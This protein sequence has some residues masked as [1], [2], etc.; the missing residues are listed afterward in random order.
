MS[1]HPS[2]SED[3]YD[4]SGFPAPPDWV[5]V[6]EVL[7]RAREA[8][9]ARLQEA[10]ELVEAQLEQREETYRETASELSTRIERYEDELEHM[11][12]LFRGSKE[13]RRRLRG[14][15]RDLRA[16]LRDVSR[17][18]WRDRQDLERERRELLRELGELEEDPVGRYVGGS[19]RSDD[20]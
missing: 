3:A 10:L 18:F 9:Q 7:E 13:D 6:E 12:D 15:I 4:G 17:V 14:H 16:E 1:H 20:Y 8:E 2:V 11:E 19:E 5:D